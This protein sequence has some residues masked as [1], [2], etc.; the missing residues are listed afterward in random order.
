[1]KTRVALCL[2]ALLVLLS[3]QGYAAT[4]RAEVEKAIAPVLASPPATGLLIFEVTDDSQAARAGFMPGDILTHY[5]GQPVESLPDLSRIARTVFQEKRKLLVL[6][7]RGEKELEA[8]F[9]PAPLGVR[10]IPVREKETRLL[11][12]PE[13][14]VP[15]SPELTAQVLQSG[16]SWEL[17]LHGDTPIGWAHS[18]LTP[19][20]GKTLLRIQSSIENEQISQQRDVIL[21]FRNEA[22]LPVDSV[23]LMSQNR[24][25]FDFFR[26]EGK[27]A[28]ERVGI[29][30]AAPI[31]EDAVSAYLSGYLAAMMPRQEGACLHCSYLAD[32][33]L[34]AAPFS[35]LYCLGAQELTIGEQTISTFKYE[36]TVFGERTAVYWVDDK[37]QVV[38]V[39]FGNG[40]T[41][42][43]SSFVEVK[44][45]Y[46]SAGEG[47]PPIESLP[48]L[49]PNTGLQ[50]N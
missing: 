9:D 23:R 18:Y 21:T 3:N 45:T 43:R 41:S 22:Y 13:T 6:A 20:K 19:H 12:R 42:R 2:S 7:R 5:D 8:E 28:G 48:V 14:P 49:A 50:A 24:L 37:N 17:L 32:S 15:F 36:Q 44:K 29:P 10:L 1:M 16:E 11:W 40:I 38:Q 33:S 31:P 46:P 26:E 30:D 35:D 34:H 47:F 25:I 39:Q 4:P 27:L